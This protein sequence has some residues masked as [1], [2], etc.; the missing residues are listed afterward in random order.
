MGRARGTERPFEDVLGA[1]QRFLRALATR[2]GDADEFELA[3]LV[4]LRDS[5]ED[6]IVVAI[7]LQLR[8][9]KSWASIGE[10]LGMRRENA[11]RKYAAL[12]EAHETREQASAPSLIR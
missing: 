12:V 2:T 10:G 7:A 8:R 11:F 1:V 9:G 5:L 6:A 3:E 4:G